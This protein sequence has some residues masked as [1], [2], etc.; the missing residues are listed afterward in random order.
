MNISIINTYDKSGGAAR[1]AYRLYRG[2][3]S[4]GLSPNYFC[5]FKSISDPA[6]HQ[7][8]DEENFNTFETNHLLIQEFINKNRT[9]VSNTFFSYPYPGI[10]LS[11]DLFIRNSDI[12]NLHWIAFFQSPKSIHNL[13]NLNIPIVWTLHDEWAY[14]GGCHYTSG[15][16][17]YL[18]NCDNCPQLNDIN[19]VIS[20]SVLNEK[21]ALEFHKITIVTPSIWLSKKAKLSRLF[22]NS[23]IECIPNAIEID[24]FFP[25]DKKIAKSKFSIPENSFTILFGADS[26]SEKRKG[27]QRLLDALNYIYQLDEWR[28]EFEKKSI[29]IVIFGNYE[30][31]N[32]EIKFPIL[33]IGHIQNDDELSLLYSAADIFIL[34]S[35]EDNLPNTI[36]EAFSC[37]TPV[38]GYNIGGIVD[39]VV[40]QE[41]GYLADINK[42]NSLAE[43]IIESKLNQINNLSMGKRARKLIETR[44]SPNHQAQLYKSLFNEIGNRSNN[45]TVIDFQSNISDKILNDRYIKKN[46]SKNYLE[47]FLNIEKTHFRYLKSSIDVKVLYRDNGDLKYSNPNIAEYQSDTI[48]NHLRFNCQETD[49]FIEEILVFIPC[50]KILVELKEVNLLLNNEILGRIM[51][52]IEVCNYSCIFEN[53]YYYYNQTIIFKIKEIPNGYLDF[54]VKLNFNII[55]TMELFLKNKVLEK[56]LI[57]SR[58]IKLFRYLSYPIKKFYIFYNQIKSR[59][60]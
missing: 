24:V 50:K 16:L 52:P 47:Y 54:E 33:K 13:L 38:L 57:N 19:S 56:Q 46:I 9:E 48:I 20:S 32:L 37:G 40:D 58:I 44:Y 11:S 3:Q 26:T 60:K 27:F 41:T 36:L 42:P 34:P 4:A 5:R 49:I 22:K 10:D 7:V 25:R 43:K 6:I 23:R 8:F 59:L 29:S 18:T 17:K 53:N 14:T 28:I 15:C 1:A 2:L 21:V 39:M 35:L 51:H 30:D 12:I 31:K 45:K 55:N